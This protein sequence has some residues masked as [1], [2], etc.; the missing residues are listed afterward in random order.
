MIDTLAADSVDLAD[1]CCD[2]WMCSRGN[3][4]RYQIRV[5]VVRATLINLTLISVILSVNLY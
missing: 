3:G 5:R 1:A 4:A 2:N